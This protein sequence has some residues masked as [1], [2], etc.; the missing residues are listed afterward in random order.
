[1][2]CRGVA[3]VSDKDTQESRIQRLGADGRMFRNVEKI[4]QR[5]WLSHFAQPVTYLGVA[6]LASIFA[7]SAYLFLH[8]HWNA[9]EQ[10]RRQ[11]ENLAYVFKESVARAIGSADDIALQVR[12]AYERDPA[13]TDLVAW[14]TDPK[15][16][17]DLTFQFSIAGRD[18]IVTAS[19]YGPAAVGTDIGDRQH[20]RAHADSH[21]DRLFVS[22]PLIAFNTGQMTIFLTR[23]LSAPNGSFN[24]VLSVWIDL[25][26]FEKLFLPL[27]LGRDG[28]V[29]LLNLKGYILVSG[30]NG[31]VREGL[32]GKF[33]PQTPVLKVAATSEMG[34]FWNTGSAID[35]IKRLI[36]F[37]RVDDLPLIVV[38]GITEPEVFRHATQNAKI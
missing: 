17:K 8:D 29:S 30:A 5:G 3:L 33:Y 4:A 21:D 19:S 23:R 15:L 25:A 20:F 6:M 24:G 22:D 2:Y 37:R 35:Q 36:S 13:G 32:S 18:G 16:K 28:A 31:K 12:R 14:V 9:E 10:A 34:S 11:G 27:R 1:L 38:V 26:Q 7:A